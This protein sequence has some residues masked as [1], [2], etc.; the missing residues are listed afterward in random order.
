MTLTLFDCMWMKVMDRVA[1]QRDASRL[2][3]VRA[4]REDTKYQ[5]TNWQPDKDSL[6]IRSCS[7][8]KHDI[9]NFFEME[10]H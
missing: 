10:I 2:G 5:H 4:W 6:N 8:P 7:G 3:E 9:I 1:S